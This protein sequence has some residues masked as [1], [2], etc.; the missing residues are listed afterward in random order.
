[1]DVFNRME[2][3]LIRRG[4]KLS[5]NKIDATALNQCS[6]ISQINEKIELESNIRENEINNEEPSEEGII[7]IKN[8]EI[9]IKGL[10]NNIGL[11]E[12]VKNITEI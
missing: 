12:K 7:E 4:Y 1:M 6:Q 10:L 8:K 9:E 2:K 5:E 11:F 3:D